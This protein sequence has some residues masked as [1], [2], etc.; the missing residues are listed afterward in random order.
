VIAGGNKNPSIRLN[1][2]ANYFGYGYTAVIALAI[3]P[4]YFQ[5]VGVEAFGLIGFF[6][7]LQTWLSLLD[8][9]LAATLGRHSALLRGPNQNFMDFQNLLKSFELLFFGIALVT[10]LSIYLSSDWLAYSWIKP[11][12]LDPES[13]SYCIALM[14]VIVGLRLYSTM[15][16]SGINGFED[17]VWINIIQ[18]TISSLRYIGAYIFIAYVSN[19]IIRFF[20]YQLAIAILEAILLKRRFYQKLPV[21]ESQIKWLKIDWRIFK[22]SLPFTQSIAYTSVILIAITQLDKLLLSGILTLEDFGYFSL[23]TLISG[24]ILSLAIPVFLAFLPRMT[25]LLSRGDHKGML[26]AYS[27]MTQVTTWVTGALS[28]MVFIFSKE[29]L[30]SLTGSNLTYKWGDEVIYWYVAG[31]FL[32][33]LGT[34]QYY[35][36]NALGSLKLY[37]IGLTIAFVLMMPIIYGVAFSY[38]AIGTGQL[39]FFFSL[40]WFL[41]LTPIVHQQNAPNF[42][43]G[44]LINDLLPILLAMLVSAFFIWYFV[45]IDLNTTR[46]VIILKLALIGIGLLIMTLPSVRLFR[47]LLFNRLALL[48]KQSGA[49]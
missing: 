24:A 6:V 44:W 15:Y 20:E 32:F 31:S 21:F 5:H 39:W 26:N 14:G 4:F 16:R 49:N 34:F 13:V 18:F 22:K 42:H 23:I 2:I 36:Q 11:V 40:I 3:T 27:N 35:L 7:V 47:N 46:Q 45:E 41:V 43:I 30:F 17:Q 10:V 9:G 29:L 25:L 19:D 1:A 12:S 33:V 37:V 48:F 8:M 28:T 38:G